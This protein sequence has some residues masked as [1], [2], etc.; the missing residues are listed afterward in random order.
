MI[1]VI[2]QY[3][4]GKVDQ[5]LGQTFEQGERSLVI[6]T[7]SSFVGIPVAGVRAFEVQ[8]TGENQT[9]EPYDAEAPPEDENE[10]DQGE[11]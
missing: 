1:K 2:V 7:S 11:E 9:P 3:M 6:R 4:D 5:M 10:G 8:P